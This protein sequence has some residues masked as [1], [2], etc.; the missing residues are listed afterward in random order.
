MKFGLIS[1]FLFTMD[2]TFAEK[3][4]G[5]AYR[6]ELLQLLHNIYKFEEV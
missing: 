1:D 2:R 3:G 5:F 4:E 6:D